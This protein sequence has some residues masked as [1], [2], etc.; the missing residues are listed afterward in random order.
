MR[1][2]FDVEAN[3]LL[4][5]ADTIHTIVVMDIDNESGWEFADQPGYAPISKALELLDKADD[6]YAHNLLRYD[7]PVLEQVLGWKPDAR[8]YDTLVM[9]RMRFAHIAEQDYDNALQ[10]GTFNDVM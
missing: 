8:L 9:T 7:L 3:G 6:L 2:C 5:T 10:Q 1:L 4:D